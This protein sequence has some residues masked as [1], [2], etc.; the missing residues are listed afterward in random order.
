MFT[1]LCEEVRVEFSSLLFY[2]E[3]SWLSRGEVLNRVL[4]LR[5][6]MPMFS[7]RRRSSKEQE[8]FGKIMDHIFIHL[9]QNEAILPKL[10]S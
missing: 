2:T 7:E 6:A 10:I 1:V 4:Q 9:F 8:L 5:K 3:V